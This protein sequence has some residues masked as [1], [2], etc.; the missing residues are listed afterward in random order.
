MT[1]RAVIS[2]QDGANVH[3]YAAMRS[4]CFNMINKFIK[5][6]EQSGEISENGVPLQDYYQHGAVQ[7]IGEWHPNPF[8]M[9]EHGYCVTLQASVPVAR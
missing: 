3:F 7:E 5:H 2:D 6:L 9:L 4:V 1:Y 8:M